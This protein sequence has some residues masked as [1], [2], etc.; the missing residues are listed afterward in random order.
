MKK[1][2]T[3]LLIIFLTVQAVSAGG[4]REDSRESGMNGEA[5][6]KDSMQASGAMTGAMEKGSMEKD[7]IE[8]VNAMAPMDSMESMEPMEENPYG[9]P[10]LLPFTG[11]EKAAMTADTGPAVLFFFADWCP[12]CQAALKELRSRAEELGK[13]TVYIVNYDKS[14][15]LKRKYG[16]TYQHTFVRI[17]PRG[18]AL[19]V[20]NG[21]GLDEILRR[22]AMKEMN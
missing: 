14:P 4:Q 11:L 2:M 17:D 3:F 13:V 15:E 12:D 19:A 7:A 16:V 18:E 6:E 9:S 20:W 5:M 1:Y 22:T 8:P 21:G 10:N